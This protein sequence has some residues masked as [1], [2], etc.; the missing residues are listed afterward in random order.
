MYDLFRYSTFFPSSGCKYRDVLP[1]LL[2]HESFCAHRVVPC[3]GRH[4]G[5]CRWSGELRELVKHVV[6]DKCVQVG[7]LS[8][9]FILPRCS[10]CFV[11]V[12]F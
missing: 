1:K 8:L 2:M 6:K 3:P 11:L 5:A 7:Y 12:I 4:R 9:S 10:Y